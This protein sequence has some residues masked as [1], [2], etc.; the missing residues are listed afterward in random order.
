MIFHDY[1]QPVK[2]ALD[3]LR[4]KTPAQIIQEITKNPV[5]STSCKLAIYT[6]HKIPSD[7]TRMGKKYP[8]DEPLTTSTILDEDFLRIVTMEASNST[9]AQSEEE[10]DQLR[11]Q[12]M[13]QYK[14]I[15]REPQ[16]AVSDHFF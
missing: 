10:V 11:K 3:E 13:Q 16:R 12:C 14:Y 7:L 4:S 8:S 15:T 2:M 1:G 5:D 9:V 6:R